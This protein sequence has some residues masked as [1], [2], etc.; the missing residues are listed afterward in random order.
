[1]NL[2]VT[3]S[4]RCGEPIRT[5]DSQRE[6]I[7]HQSLEIAFAEEAQWVGPKVKRNSGKGFT[8]LGKNFWGHVLETEKRIS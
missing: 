2:A 6:L 5:V 3:L 1:M 8:Q 7:V 4:V